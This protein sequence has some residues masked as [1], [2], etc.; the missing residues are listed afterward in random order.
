MKHCATPIMPQNCLDRAVQALYLNAG[1]KS[2]NMFGASLIQRNCGL[3]VPLPN[4]LPILVKACHRLSGVF[5]QHGFLIVFLNTA[6]YSSILLMPPVLTSPLKMRI[7]TS[8]LKMRIAMKWGLYLKSCH[9][10]GPIPRF[11]RVYKVKVAQDL[12]V[13][14]CTCCHQPRMGRPCRHIAFVCRGN[15]TIL[16][17]NPHGNPLSSICVF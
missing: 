16:G 14:P 13:F 3:T 6:G 9:A 12:Q 10:F 15:D 2:I 4:M 1:N 17:P 8:P 5:R 7:S 11:P